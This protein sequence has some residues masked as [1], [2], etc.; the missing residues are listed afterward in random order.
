M[1][2]LTGIA[3]CT[4]LLVIINFFIMT[5]HQAT[6]PI[7]EAS[8]EIPEGTVESEVITCADCSTQLV[9]EKISAEGAQVSEAPEIEEDW[10]E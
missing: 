2:F 7:C 3:N 6:C 8:V 4:T 9:V 1:V 5:A 10:G